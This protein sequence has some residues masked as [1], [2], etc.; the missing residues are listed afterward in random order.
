MSNFYTTNN[1]DFSTPNAKVDSVTNKPYPLMWYDDDDTCVYYADY[2][3]HPLCQKWRN[4]QQLTCDENFRVGCH[5][6]GRNRE[7]ENFYRI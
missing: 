4:E 1:A 5:E 3:V 7:R 6:I 2:V